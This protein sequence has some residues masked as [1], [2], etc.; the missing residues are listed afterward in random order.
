MELD[1]NVFEQRFD[2]E[3]EL[4]AAA[5]CCAKL[6]IFIQDE[7]KAMEDYS[8]IFIKEQLINGNWEEI[9]EA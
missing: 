4:L 8:N 2:T 3:L 5:E 6:L 1:N 9:D 7:K